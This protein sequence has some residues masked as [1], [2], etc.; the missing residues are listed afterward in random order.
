MLIN[1]VGV[2]VNES[3]YLNKAGKFLFK[4][5]KWE[6][7]GV[8]QYGDAKFKLSF[9]G[10]EVGTKEPVYLHSEMFNIG[11]KSLWRIKQ[12]EVALKSPEVY[13]LDSWIG[14][15]VIAN[16]SERKYTKND[17]TEGVAYDC[18][19]WE[20]SPLNDKLAPIPAAQQNTNNDTTEPVE[21]DEIPF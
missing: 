20:H 18:K 7:D 13:L 1:T 4:I 21:T 17:G 19:S 6:E 5:E 9:K 2:E 10:V 8:T 12:L 15:Y 16:V 14:R 11:Q 3:T